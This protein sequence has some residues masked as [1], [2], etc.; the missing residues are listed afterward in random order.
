MT[1][2]QILDLNNLNA[3]RVKRLLAKQFVHG[4]ILVDGYIFDAVALKA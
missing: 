4:V 1:L 3:A 2:K